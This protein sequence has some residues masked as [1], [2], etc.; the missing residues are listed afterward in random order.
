ML[1]PLLFGLILGWHRVQN[2]R[3]LYWL[4][5]FYKRGDIDDFPFVLVKSSDRY[6]NILMRSSI[7]KPKWFHQPVNKLCRYLF[8]FLFMDLVSFC[9]LLFLLIYFLY[10]VDVF[11]VIV[12]HV[13]SDLTLVFSLLN[14]L[15]LTLIPFVYLC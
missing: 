14:Q 11:P 13:V 3:G 5:S 6:V 10:N 2:S 7:S 12:G 1:L 8:D 15:I 9:S 4:L